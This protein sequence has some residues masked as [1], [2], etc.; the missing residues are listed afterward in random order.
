MFT[1]CYGS[2]A[3]SI[4]ENCSSPIVGGYTGRG[5]L[6]D[7]SLNPTITVDASNNHIITAVTLTQ[8]Q[9]FI[10]ISNVWNDAFTG[11][12]T[13]SGADNGRTSFNKTFTFRIPD[14][15][16]GISNDVVE[17]LTFSPLGYMA[18]LEKKDRTGDG[19]FEI[20]GYKRALTVNAD[21]VTR[22]EYEN[23]GDIVITMGTNEPWFETVLYSS[24]YSA[25]LTAFE[26]MLANCL[27]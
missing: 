25:T 20:I 4:K 13:S 6:V 17:P 19:S 27:D 21:G 24:S 14:R 10:A 16:A 23:G 15:G 22:N 12:A 1:T 7:L 5:I 2:V 26:A 8:S 18:I 11:S 3:Q 9:K